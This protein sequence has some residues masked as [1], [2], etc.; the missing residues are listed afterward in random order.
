MIKKIFFIF[1]GMFLLA[2][3]I[4]PLVSAHC[5]LCTAGAAA[6][7]G[8]SRV[9][10]IDDSISGLFIGAAI[11]SSA[12]WFNRWLKKKVN[13]PLQEVVIILASFLMFAIP[14]YFSGIIINFEMVRSM[15]DTHSMLGMGVFG[16]DKLL[17][18]MIVGSLA[19]WFVFALSDEIKSRRGKVLWSYQGLSFM[20][21]A[22]LL[23]SLIF[24]IITK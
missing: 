3:I 2:G 6:G 7:L 22:L 1:I 24:W 11:I 13:F 17:F 19:S 23:L 8:I 4:S 20:A 10:G 21:I 16:I 9:L 18:G 12:L 14:F 5:P 15:P